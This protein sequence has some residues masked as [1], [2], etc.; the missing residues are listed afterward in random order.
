MKFIKFYSV[1]SAALIAFFIVQ[2]VIFLNWHNE[3][4]HSIGAAL[5]ALALSWWIVTIV[6]IFKFKR[7]GKSFLLPLAWIG[8]QIAVLA[9][10]IPLRPVLDSNATLNTAWLAG[11]F[12][13]DA[14]FLTMF[15]LLARRLLTSPEQSD[16]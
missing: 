10:G 7:E 9:F 15:A 13:I 1:A 14:G 6:A 3:T 16:A 12:V 5:T 11:L 8:Y 4:T 2:R